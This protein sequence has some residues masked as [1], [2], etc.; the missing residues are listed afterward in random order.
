M[1]KLR[2]NNVL[3]YSLQVL[4]RMLLVVYP[5]YEMGAHCDLNPDQNGD[6]E[7]EPE[8]WI[9]ACPCFKVLLR[10]VYG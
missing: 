2:G 4:V 7:I 6:G 3:I 10:V 5:G 1:E 9:K 8:S